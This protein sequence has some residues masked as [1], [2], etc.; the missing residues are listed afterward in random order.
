MRMRPRPIMFPG[1]Q[2]GLTLFAYLVVTIIKVIAPRST[3]PAIAESLFLKLQLRILDRL[4]R[5]VPRVAAADRPLLN[6]GIACEFK[7][8]SASRWR[9]AVSTHNQGVLRISNAPYT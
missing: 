2:N 1:M 3:R 6:L 4:R 9:G 5:N 8:H 7:S